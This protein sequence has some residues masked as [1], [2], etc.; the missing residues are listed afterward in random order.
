MHLSLAMIASRRDSPGAPI[1]HRRS[2]VSDVQP[3]SE[4]SAS[5]VHSNSESNG[6]NKTRKRRGPADQIAIAR[7]LKEIAPVGDWIAYSQLSRD[8]RRAVLPF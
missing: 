1:V 6:A 2:N 8:Q 3:N 5:E 4:D 7:G